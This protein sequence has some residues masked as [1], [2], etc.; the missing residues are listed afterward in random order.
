MWFATAINVVIR[1]TWLGLTQL[2]ISI[3]KQ[4]ILPRNTCMVRN[5]KEKMYSFS[6][7]HLE[8]SS[9][10]IKLSVSF[11]LQVCFTE[12]PL[13]ILLFPFQP[14]LASAFQI[15]AEAFAPSSCHREDTLLIS[16]LH[17]FSTSNLLR[18]FISMY[19][20]NNSEITQVYHLN[21]FMIYPFTHSVHKQPSLC[22]GS[23]HANHP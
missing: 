10:K 14:C 5:R 18:Q 16:N 12:L 19:P 8:L 23:S 21:I 20:E 17:S 11:K 2:Q 7:T 4:T 15:T 13:Q 9:L 6:D 22:T 1:T 3:S